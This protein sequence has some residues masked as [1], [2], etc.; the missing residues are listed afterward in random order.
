MPVESIVDRLAALPMFASVPR[1]ELEWLAA[2]GE[3]RTFG[4]GDVIRD[5][6]QPADEMSVLVAGRAALYAD[7]G[8]TMRKLIEAGAGFVLGLLPYSR[9]QQAPGTTIIEEDAVALVLNQ[10]HFPTLTRELPALTT[11]LVHH[12]LDRAREYRAV[13]L[14]DDRLQS[15]SRLAA[16]F[17]HELNNPASAA[18]RTAKSMAGL[19]EEQERAARD[20]AAARLGDEQLAV[21]DAIRSACGT[22]APRRTALEAA[23]RE[24]DLLEWLDQ[25]G[26]ASQAAEALAASNVSLSELEH[27]ASVLP[28]TALEIATRWIASG[29]AARVAS[30]QIEAATGRIH[31][32][33]GAV[34][35]FT[36]MDREGVPEDVD[37]AR[38]LADTLAMLEGKARAKS[39][40]VHLETA[41]DLPRAKGFGSEINQVWQ[42]LVDNALDAVG[43]QGRVTIT[44]TTRGDSILVRIADD[45]PGI[46]EEIRARIFDPFFTTKPVGQGTGL[47]LDMARR[48]VHLHGGDID[49]TTDP[50]RTVFRVRLPAAGRSQGG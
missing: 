17:A 16:G 38:G 50:G 1:H 22:A 25:H 37:V 8:G 15:L 4:A 46:P 31:E 11:A 41:A 44:A 49:F 32:L 28:E 9:Y 18:A 29:C 2:H 45:G 21:I 35:G 47:G 26:L 24:D 27:L 36:F 23:D 48:I 42:K 3:V 13:Q 34:K 5:P 30:R 10:R 40:T 43:T 14:N 33:V 20:L 7:K 6:S 39:A 12:M 19:L